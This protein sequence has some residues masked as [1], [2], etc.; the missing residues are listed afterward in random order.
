MCRAVDEV[1]H[2]HIRKGIVS[3]PIGAIKQAERK[4]FYLSNY[5]VV[6]FH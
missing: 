4:E 5:I 1:C 6:S 3:V 2:K